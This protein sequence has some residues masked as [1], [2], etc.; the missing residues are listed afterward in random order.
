MAKQEENRSP[1]LKYVYS[2]FVQ[3]GDTK[4]AIINGMEYTIGDAVLDTSYYVKTITPQ[5]VVLK[6]IDSPQTISISM[7]ETES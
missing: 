7:S 6:R 5:Q 1:L 3:M 2:G 4:F